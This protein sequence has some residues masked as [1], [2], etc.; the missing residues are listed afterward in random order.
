MYCDDLARILLWS[1]DNAH[2]GESLVA[3]TDETVTIRQLAEATIRAAGLNPERDLE[4]DRRYSGGE[5]ERKADNRLLK[6][7]MG[8]SLVF[9]PLEQGLRET[10]AWFETAKARGC[11]VRGSIE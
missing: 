5:R 11:P 6:S 2:H 10:F 1:L 8:P 3:S 9:T 4:F 7:R